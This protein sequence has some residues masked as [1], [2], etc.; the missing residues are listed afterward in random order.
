LQKLKLKKLKN[1]IFNLY[2]KEIDIALT[3]AIKD[4][5][6]LAFTDNISIIMINSNRIK[7]EDEILTAI[8]HELVHI[9]FNLKDGTEEFDVKLT[10]VNEIITTKYLE[11][12]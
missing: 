4:D 9:V 6:I 12:K 11:V 5:G 2:G 3:T 1:I 10:A 7:S 8:S